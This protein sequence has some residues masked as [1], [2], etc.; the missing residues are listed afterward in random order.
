MFTRQD[1]QYM[2]LALAQALLAEAAEEVPVGAVL[3][4][5]DR[6]LASAHNRTRTQSDPSAH[7]EIMVLR[8]AGSQLGSSRLTG[9]TLYVTIEPCVMC[10]G[11]LVQSRI[12]RLVYGAREP[13]TGAVVSAFDLLMSERH[14]HRV[15][16]TEGVLADECAE[17]MQRFFNARR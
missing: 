1:R 3:V 12:Q 17:L 7:A 16:I 2:Q 11:A 9:T 8:D 4:H 10:V 13:R 14:N 6:V 5:D 15:Q